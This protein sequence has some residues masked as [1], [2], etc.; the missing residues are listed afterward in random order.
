MTL[1]DPKLI[2]ITQ[3]EPQ[4]LA[5]RFWFTLPIYPYSKRRT[6]RTEVV[7]D[8]IWTFDQVQ[9][10][11]YVIVPIRMTV[12]KLVSGGLLVYAPVAPTVECLRLVNELVAIHGEVRG[13]QLYGWLRGQQPGRE[14]PCR[15]RHWGHAEVVDPRVERRS[16]HATEVL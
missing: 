6:I 3:P 11:F 4:D 5:W 12:V 9:G 16:G 7:Q 1:G 10:I 13:R 8:T 15:G 14:I 2:P